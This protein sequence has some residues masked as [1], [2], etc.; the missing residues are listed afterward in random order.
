MQLKYF[1]R[2]MIATVRSLFSLICLDLLILPAPNWLTKLHLSVIIFLKTDQ[3]I[4]YR[5]TNAFDIN[6]I[7]KS[8]S[9]ETSLSQNFIL[10][11]AKRLK[12]LDH[13]EHNNRATH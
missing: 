13:H 9:K 7:N 3:I 6:F 2:Q 10:S 4:D 1:T 8:I 12:A 5:S 11:F